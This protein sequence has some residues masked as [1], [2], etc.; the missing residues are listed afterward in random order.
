MGN[1]SW[2]LPYQGSK[3]KIAGWVVANLFPGKRLVDVFGGGGAITHYAVVNN[4]KGLL[5]KKFEEFHYNELSPPIYNA[6]RGVTTGEIEVR[7]EGSRWVTREEFNLAKDTDGLMSLIWSFGN[8]RRQ[9]CYSF[10]LE[11]YKKAQH[12]FFSFG[13]VGNLADEFEKLSGVKIAI[14]YN[15]KNGHIARRKW[16]AEQVRGA[17]GKNWGGNHSI[18]N[19][20]E[21]HHF[22][23]VTRAENLGKLNNITYSNLS[24]NKIE[25]RAG[26]ILYCDPP[27]AGTK[28][29]NGENFD[30]DKFLKWAMAC[31]RPVFV[32]EYGDL[33]DYG[34]ELISYIKKSCTFVPNVKTRKESLEKIWW[35][36]RT[37]GD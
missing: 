14:E 33:E 26:D 29:Y 32:S 1:I 24:Y 6:F 30:N 31:P 8:A 19:F 13:T 36:G 9:Y 10:V 4:L 16:W 28:G 2:G 11:A 5:G 34:F 27:Y 23:G 37:Y 20:E 15:G 12:N 21:A 35:N 25:L 22:S 17:L 7:A 18:R 3:N